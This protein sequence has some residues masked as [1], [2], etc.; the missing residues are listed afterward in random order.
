MVWDPLAE[1]TENTDLKRARMRIVLILDSNLLDGIWR[2]N[3]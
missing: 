3:M 1:S 2:L